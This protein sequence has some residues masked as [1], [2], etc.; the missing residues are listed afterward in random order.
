MIYA[1]AHPHSQGRRATLTIG[2]K[3]CEYLIE[4]KDD[5]L[6]GPALLV[7]ERI[8]AQIGT[9]SRGSSTGRGPRSR[10]AAVLASSPRGA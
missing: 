7:G 5:V 10:S 2:G 3:D 6:R 1:S 9:P 4:A 8:D